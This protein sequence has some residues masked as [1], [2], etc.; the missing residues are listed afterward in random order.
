M[1]QNQGLNRTLDMNTDK[2]SLGSVPWGV[3][4]AQLGITENY[5]VRA[6]K[7]CNAYI[8]QLRRHYAAAH[9]GAKVP[10]TLEVCPNPHDYGVYFD[11]GASLDSN[12]AV[13]AALWLE[14]N[15]PEDWD[16]RAAHELGLFPG[17]DLVV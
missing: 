3:T 5:E 13:V 4:P 6:E 7:E 15:M 14:K 9:N 17:D 2:L 16:H 11:V 8:R 1:D 10:C 12:E